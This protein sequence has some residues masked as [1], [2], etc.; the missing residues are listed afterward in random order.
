MSPIIKKSQHRG[1]DPIARTLF[2]YLEK[3][4]GREIC[5]L[6]DASG[7][8]ITAE[9][10]SREIGG[11][12]AAHW[13]AIVSPT[14][15]DCAI[16]TERHGGDRQAAAIAQ[17][18]AIAQR[19]ERDT[20]RRVAFAVHI[21]ERDGKPHFHYHFVGHGEAR[22]RLYGR[23]GVIQRAWDRAWNPDQ[24]RIQNWSEHRA[25][26]IAQEEL[27]SVQ[28]QMR[29]LGEERRKAIA[30]APPERKLEVR[31]SFKEQELAL[32][33]RRYKL[34]VL[35]IDHRYAARN[36][37]GSDRHQAELIDAT[38]R[39][40]GAITRVH[41][42]GLPR[43]ALVGSRT[44][45]LATG[46]ATA[47]TSH[48]Q[49]GVR[50][51]LRGAGTA[52]TVN[53]GSLSRS[54]SAPVAQPGEMALAVARTTLTTAAR[55]AVSLALKAASANPPGLVMQ[56]AKLSVNAPQKLLD[57]VLPDRGQLP[58]ELALP[59]RAASA[60]PGLGIVANVATFATQ[61]TLRPILKE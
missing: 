54:P 55:T 22:V 48:L 29:I 31:E 2:D 23:S 41:H 33:A 58:Q 27:R 4:E 24:K 40:K 43:E 45:R 47:A 26:I 37:L 9:E 12:R 53:G 8:P 32:V 38:N 49:Q 46:L 15:Q 30:G 11:N 3:E 21:E 16:L 57:L 35:A 20:G 19:L 61:E 14:F 60:V 17:G 5:L 51:V 39:Q 59:L 52:L 1:K 10:L 6:L 34:E 50:G 42:R 18:R 28:R 7:N 36:D 13:H 44:G 25:F 56:V